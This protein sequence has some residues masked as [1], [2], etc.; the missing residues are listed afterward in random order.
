MATATG[1]CPRLPWACRSPRCRLLSCGPCPSWCSCPGRLV[2]FEM[3]RTQTGSLSWLG[4]GEVGWSRAP[5]RLV[6]R[7]IGWVD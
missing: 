5:S 3:A 2:H 1:T 7:R 4:E 6:G